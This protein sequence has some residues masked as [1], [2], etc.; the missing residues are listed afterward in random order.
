MRLLWLLFVG[1]LSLGLCA[2]A[3]ASPALASLCA[4]GAP[5]APAEECNSIPSPLPILE[6]LNDGHI[7]R[8]PNSSPPADFCGARCQI[9]RKREAAKVAGD[10]QAVKDAQAELMALPNLRVHLVSH[11]HDDAGWKKTVD[12][13]YNNANQSL[14]IFR[15]GVKYIITNVLMSL[16]RNSA[17]QFIQ[18][19]Q[20]YFSKW[21]EAQTPAIQ[22]K[23]QNLVSSGQ[24]SFVNGGWVMHDEAC[25]WF[26]DM[27]DQTTVGQQYL[28]E[29]F[30]A[31]GAVNTGQH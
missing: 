11:S 2:S 20:V 8:R 13:Y 30:G 14:A 3:S 29:T 17:R 1:V 25:M 4:A 28:A 10:E 22:Q 5:G 9:V 15:G 12:Q 26:Q 7:R 24:L 6:N 19:E 18:T 21:Y 23:A 16:E 27:I 31:N